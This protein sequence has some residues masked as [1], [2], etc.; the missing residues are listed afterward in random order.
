MT[1][2]RWRP[3]PD[4]EGRYDVSDIGEVRSIP[5]TDRLGRSQ[6][7][8]VLKQHARKSGH[9]TVVLYGSDGRRTMLVHTLVATAFICPRPTGLEV[10]HG[11][12]D[13][14]NNRVSNLRW[15]THS[16][17]TIDRVRHGAHHQTAK[18]V[19]PVGHALRAPNLSAAAV[20]KGHRTCLACE[21]AHAAARHAGE[22]F[23][24][25]L[26]DRKYIEIMNGSAA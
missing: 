8:L 13:P 20:R 26:A 14:R 18:A 22:P 10:C 3:V 9:R 7:G 21:R 11:D 17:N 5:R 4:Y 15:D 2:A 19:C 24:R 1:A 23:D 12:G 25:A 16:E 6:G